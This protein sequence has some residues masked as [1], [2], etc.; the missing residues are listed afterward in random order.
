[1]RLVV[2]PVVVVTVM[3][4]VMMARVMAAHVVMAHVVMAQVVMAHVMMAH[5]MA[6]T[7][8]RIGD[9][10]HGARSGGWRALCERGS[11]GQH[12]REGGGAEQ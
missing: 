8:R 2:A 1:M 5:V 10:L 4:G 12:G 3:Q 6:R 11:R 7:F 9:R